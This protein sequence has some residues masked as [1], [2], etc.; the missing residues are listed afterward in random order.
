MR[1][2][3]REILSKV[4]L[5][6]GNVNIE[7][8]GE[9][10]RYWLIEGEGESGIEEKYL[11]YN[12]SGP[13]YS[14]DYGSYRE[15]MEQY[16]DVS[17]PI[18]VFDNWDKEWD[19]RE[20]AYQKLKKATDRK[21]LLNW[22][23]KKISFYTELES[24]LSLEVES[25]GINY[26]EYQTDQ[27][28]EGVN[29]QHELAGRVYNISFYELKKIFNVRGK[30]LFRR[31]VRF[32]LKKNK[33]GNLLQLRFKE[34]IKIGAYLKWIEEHPEDSDKEEV[35]ALFEIEEGFE[36]RHPGHFWFYHN[37]I[38]LFYYGDE[39]V[40]FS[41]NHIKFNPQKVSVINGAQTLTNFFEG[42]KMLPGEFEDTCSN[43]IEDEARRKE[44]NRHLQSCIDDMV[45]KMMVKTVF[46][47]G[48]EEY[49]QP[50]TYG[51][52][53]QIPILETDIIADST[54]VEKINGYLLKKNMKITKA[55]EEANIDKPLSVLEFTKYFLI[56]KGE[57]GK[58]KNLLRSDI[59]KYIQEAE[60]ALENSDGDKLVN[61]IY[62]VYLGEE[63]WKSSK[64]IREENYGS[65]GE[66]IYTKNAKNYFESFVLAEKNN[67]LDDEY[68]MLLYDM[69]IERFMKLNPS[70]EI[71]DFKKDDL[72]QKYK[73]E[74]IASN[75]VK[76]GNVSGDICE[77]LKDFL[78][79]Q[80][81][82]PYTIQK[83]IR[84]FLNSK[85][86][87]IPYFRVISC[88]NGKVREAFPFSASTFS[89]IYQNQTESDQEK[90]YISFEESSFKK[91]IMKEFPIFI[92]DWEL[93]EEKRKV[94]EVYFV[95]NFSFKKLEQDAKT[96]FERTIKAF[97]DGDEN[98]LPKMGEGL[99]FHV[100]PKA[101]NAEDTFEFSNGKQITKRTF[102]VNKNTMNELLESVMNSKR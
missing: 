60:S 28:Q 64:K 93:T 66:L 51:L 39:K 73:K 84:G 30:E 43:L 97:E 8:M 79:S 26:L 33:T 25:D 42:L 58:S 55:G 71:K 20:Q 91:E 49:V 70:P 92:I 89:E 11:V 2:L 59:E 29:G 18:I 22:F 47:E 48:P 19:L 53:T 69:F 88:S 27:W 31:N 82:S 46:I 12:C 54:E 61:N 41:G 23:E 57:P 50:I 21:Q 32:G 75:I 87:E 90:K 83:K 6:N 94:D 86:I 62:D 44:F 68:F 56:T 35:R 101:I 36:T 10:K 95:E 14:F 77:G 102:W 37:G 1:D 52:N 16:E 5:E 34:Y 80:E 67:F 78:N 7:S 81:L 76:S 85:G 100:R 72:F 65:G 38:T 99:S 4:Q 3:L 74:K 40:D 96:V 15:M 63:W 98:S 9:G 45:H 17:I 24:F 13:E